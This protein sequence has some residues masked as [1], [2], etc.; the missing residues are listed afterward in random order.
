MEPHREAVIVVVNVA[1]RMFLLARWCLESGHPEIG[2]L[3]FGEAI[4]LLRVAIDLI[5]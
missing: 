3:L 5:R 4:A 2:G 1:R